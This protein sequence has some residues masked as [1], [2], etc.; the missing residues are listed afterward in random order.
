MNSE[1][2]FVIKNE[3]KEIETLTEE[4]MNF[5]HENG[6]EESACYDI[7]LSLEEVVSNTIRYGYDHDRDRAI[8]VRAVCEPQQMTLEIEDD[9]RAFN[10]L[11]AVKAD[12][13][14]PMEQRPIGGLGIYLVNAVM[15][16]VEYRRVESKNILRLTKHLGSV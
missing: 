9:A 6:I 3:L 8:R 7:R 4:V 15:D 10:P 5:C 14:L 13:S 1:K 2:V 11:E 12:V 16:R